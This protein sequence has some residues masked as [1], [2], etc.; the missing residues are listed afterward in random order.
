MKKLSLIFILFIIFLVPLFA[1]VTPPPDS[2]LTLDFTAGLIAN[3]GFS[4]VRRRKVSAAVFRERLAERALH[5][6]KRSARRLCAGVRRT[7]CPAGKT[8]LPP[9][10]YVL[11]SVRPEYANARVFLPPRHHGGAF[12]APVRPVARGDLA[13]FCGRTHLCHRSR[14]RRARRGHRLFP[15]PLDRRYLAPV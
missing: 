13:E 12:V 11:R 9:P 8:R 5:P 6:R 4:S 10:R 2:I 3:L 7:R 1:V 15:R 14:H